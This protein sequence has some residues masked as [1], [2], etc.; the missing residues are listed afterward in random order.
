MKSIVLINSN[1]TL[2]STHGINFLYHP[3]DGGKAMVTNNYVASIVEIT[4][5]ILQLLSLNED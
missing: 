1:I 3:I 4:I 5:D 2:I